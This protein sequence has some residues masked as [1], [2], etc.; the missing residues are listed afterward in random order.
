MQR[1]EG[2]NANNHPISRH[3]PKLADRVVLR[4]RVRPAAVGAIV[5]TG[6]STV[7]DGRNVRIMVVQFG[8]TPKFDAEK[9]LNRNR[10]ERNDQDAGLCDVAI[11]SHGVA[12]SDVRALDEGRS[13]RRFLTTWEGKTLMTIIFVA[14]VLGLICFADLV[15]RQGPELAP[16]DRPGV[17]IIVRSEV[18]RLWMPEATELAICQLQCPA[19]QTHKELKQFLELHDQKGLWYALT[20]RAYQV[21]GHFFDLTFVRQPYKEPTHFP[22]FLGIVAKADGCPPRDRIVDFSRGSIHVIAGDLSK[23][24]PREVMAELLGHLSPAADPVWQ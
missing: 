9:R 22:E 10:H 4:Q 24:E 3:K 21:N 15:T 8:V 6:I 18:L 20:A 5:N 12:G 16:A 11:V 17:G 23:H 7:G 1:W 2:V 13:S 14:A 19:L